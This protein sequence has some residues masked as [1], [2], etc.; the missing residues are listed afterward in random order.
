GGDLQTGVA[1]AL[2]HQYAAG[3]LGEGEPVD[4]RVVGGRHGGGDAVLEGDRVQVRPGGF[5]LVPE[6]ELAALQAGSGLGTGGGQDGELVAV[7]HPDAG[8]VGEADRL[9]GG[10][11]LGVVGAL[12]GIQGAGGGRIG[13]RGDEVEPVRH[14]HG[15]ERVA[16]GEAAGGVRAAPGIHVGEE[17]L[18]GVQGGGGGDADVVEVSA[19]GGAGRGV[20]LVV[21]EHDARHR[22]PG[23]GAQVH[24]HRVPLAGPED[25]A[26]AL[27]A[28][29]D[30]EAVG[31]LGVGGREPGAVGEDQV[32]GR[33]GGAVGEVGVEH[34]EDGVVQFAVL[35]DLQVHLE[36]FIGGGGVA[37]GE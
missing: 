13:H 35:G 20:R 22:A 36:Q 14:G 37:V 9:Q 30:S 32:H 21:G 34:G 23:E 29:G 19:D 7:T 16:P 18:G 27:G 33:I 25:V 26:L 6:G 10:Q 2:V 31:I 5:V 8:L 4:G 12:V 28:C 3:V 15:R 24:R 11:V 1:H 17:S